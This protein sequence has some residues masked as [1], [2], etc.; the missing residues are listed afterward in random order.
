MVACLAGQNGLGRIANWAGCENKVEKGYGLLR[1][2]GLDLNW[3]EGWFLSQNLN[4]FWA[5]EF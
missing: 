5:T 3:N 4:G 1:F 2:F